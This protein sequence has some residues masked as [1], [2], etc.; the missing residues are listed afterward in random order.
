MTDTRPN[1]STKRTGAR[2]SKLLARQRPRQS[3]LSTEDQAFLTQLEHMRDL[4]RDRTRAVAER[5][6]NGCYVV[7]RPGSSKTYTILEEL[8]R[9][10]TPWT[11]RNSRMT[12]AG[13]YA[14]LQE[15]PEHTV[16][17]DDIPSLVADRSGLQV[18]MAALG[19]EPGSPRPLTYTTA[20]GRKSFDFTAGVIAVSN[21][22]LRRDPLADAVQS[23]VPLLE[24]EPS[25]EMLAAFMRSQATKGFEDLTPAECQEVVELVIA[26]SRTCN[27]RLDLRATGKAWQDFRLWK[28]GKA[29]REWRDLIVSGLKRIVVPQAPHTNSGGTRASTR[30]RELDLARE[31]YERFPSAADK[32]ERDAAWASATGKSVDTLYRRRRQLTLTDDPS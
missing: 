11:Y 1:S 23:R 17:L 13:L 12:V 5:Y 15:H 8:K 24:H 26:E 25:D 28:H 16:V 27:Y 10:D 7:G 29:H 21:V 9:L 32:V 3:S 4:L 14:L 22:P 2:S 19:G 20:E 18:L 30:R 31:L 6:Q